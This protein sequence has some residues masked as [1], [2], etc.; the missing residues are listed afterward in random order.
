MF[1]K[2]EELIRNNRSL[3]QQLSEGTRMAQYNSV[4]QKQMDSYE[5]QLT[6]TKE[7]MTRAKEDLVKAKEEIATMK[8]EHTKMKVLGDEREETMV[9]LSEQTEQLISRNEHL[10]QSV[11]EAA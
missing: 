3:Q 10:Q 8:A 11:K 4:N 5:Q 7:E 2:H 9:R 1:N 6:K